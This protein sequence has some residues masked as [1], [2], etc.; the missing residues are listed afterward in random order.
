MGNRPLP[1]WRSLLFVPAN[2]RR[3][4]DKAHTRGADAII[5]DLE[6]S[7]P[8]AEKAGARQSVAA[9]A[10]QL[11][12]A[13]CNGVLIRIN[14]PWRL[15]LRDLE[16]VVSPAVTGIVLPKVE[17][18]EAVRII[19]EVLSELEAERG[20]PSGAT[21]LVAIIESAAGWLRCAEIAAADPRLTAIAL[22]PEDFAASMGIR[23]EPASLLFPCQQIVIAARAAGIV[24]IGFAGSIGEYRDLNAYRATIQQARGL[25]FHG[26]MCIHPAQVA[27][28]NEE[29]APTPEEVAYAQ[30]VVAAYAEALQ[31]GR[32]ATGLDGKMIDPPVVAQAQAVLARYQ[33][34]QKRS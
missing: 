34:I 24:P 3:I 17:S 26:A 6:D 19:S 25:G 9:A 15:A 20:M 29:L 1:V 30:R 21:C 16:A 10:S 31:A 8:L 32:G 22:G 14:Q 18:A 23:P 7:V 4:I 33:A 12:Q 11:D 13:G 27:V 2:N 5:L 28:V